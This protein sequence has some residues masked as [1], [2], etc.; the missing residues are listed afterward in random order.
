ML[1]N[2]S[3]YAPSTYQGTY[4]GLNDSGIVTFTTNDTGYI[5]S[6]VRE[7][8]QNSL[9]AV[10]DK[11]KPVKVCFKSFDMPVEKFPDKNQFVRMLEECLSENRD[12]EDIASF[13]ERA[14]QIAQKPVKVFRISDY[15][16]CGLSGADVEGRASYNTKWGSLVKCNGTP[17]QNNT[18]GGSYG[19]GKSVTFLCSDLR[20]VFYSSLDEKN[21]K[22]TVGVARLISFQDL[23]HTDM[24]TTGSV[25]FAK[26]PTKIN[27]IL[28]LPDFEPGYVREETGT[29]IYIM[30]M[31]DTENLRLELIRSVLYNFLVS[32][33]NQQLVV[34]LDNEENDIISKETLNKYV[35]LIVNQTDAE[36]RWKESI[37]D[38]NNYYELL[39][40]SPESNPDVK[41]IPLRAE[42]YGKEYGFSDGDATLYL[43][44]RQ[45]ANRHVLMTREKGMR[46][47]E[48]NRLPRSIDFTGI[49]CITGE[50]MNSE[51]RKMET[52]SHDKWVETSSPCRGNEKKYRKMR[53][54]LYS[55][56]KK[57]IQNSFGYEIKE[58]IDAFG[59]SEFLP[60]YQH[61]EG[62]TDHKSVFLPGIKGGELKIM[63]PVTP[64]LSKPGSV[65]SDDDDGMTGG[66]SPSGGAGGTGSNSRKRKKG[67]RGGKGGKVKRLSFKTIPL[68]DVRSYCKDAKQGE[69]V[70]SFHIPHTAKQAKLKFNV[71]GEQS[72]F[73][74]AVKDVNVVTG[75]STAKIE[76]IENAENTEDSYILLDNLKVG[77]PVELDVKLDFDEFCLLEVIY[78]EAK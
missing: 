25:Y 75:K 11:K 42:E 45:D 29:D 40:S 36:N 39:T 69:F 61:E 33:W 21:I 20:T 18:A 52:P 66:N 77:H 67:G 17:N 71:A 58:E 72:A 78:S 23:N 14:I 3:W 51:F 59:A 38:L 7:T 64:A 47:F 35:P 19:I 46:I 32:I 54:G 76:K 41:V 26:S 28:S 30:G 9:D 49:F 43:L 37:D 5:N 8:I 56:I 53:K 73:P 60:D 15:N 34:I 68:T 74:V 50:K 31:T 63:K 4:N 1:E 65:L 62:N 16:T 22:S 10:L 44:R 27:A 2:G 70:V 55:Y 57:Q 48:Q 6:L 13:F 24:M 12:K